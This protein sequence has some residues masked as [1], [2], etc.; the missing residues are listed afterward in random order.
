MNAITTTIYTD[1]SDVTVYPSFTGNCQTCSL[2]NFRN[3]INNKM[4]SRLEIYNKILELIKLSGKKMFLIDIHQGIEEEVLKF[5]FYRKDSLNLRLPYTSTNDS[6]M[7]I[8]LILKSEVEYLLAD[9]RNDESKLLYTEFEQYMEKKNK[10]SN[11]KPIISPLEVSIV[12]KLENY[13]HLHQ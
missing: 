13:E 4:F 12:N 11:T 6:L 2:S 7:V 1:D 8:Y 3:Y 10:N 5:L 9:H